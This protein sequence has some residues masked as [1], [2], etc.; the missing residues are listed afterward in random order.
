LVE[1]KLKEVFDFYKLYSVYYEV[2][3]LTYFLKQDLQK[4]VDYLLNFYDFLGIIFFFSVVIII[5]FLIALI[6][7]SSSLSVVSLKS[8]SSD[9][10]LRKLLS[11]GVFLVINLFGKLFNE[12]IFLSFGVLMLLFWSLKTFWNIFHFY[13]LP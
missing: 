11:I 12:A 10:S 8:D 6:M 9:S 13:F 2:H 3:F 4:D 7:I 5:H 1:L